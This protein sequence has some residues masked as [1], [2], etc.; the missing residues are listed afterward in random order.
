M[1]SRLLDRTD[2]SRSAFTGLCGETRICKWVALTRVV[3]RARRAR[4]L[5]FL[6]CTSLH[7]PNRRGRDEIHDEPQGVAGRGRAGRGAGAAVGAAGACRA[8]RL[9]RHLQD[10]GRGLSTLEGDGD[11]QLADR[12]LRSAADQLARLPQSRR[13]GGERDDVMGPRQR[14]AGALSFRTR[15]VQRQVLDDSHDAGRQLSGDRHGDGVDAWDGRRGQ[16]RR[17]V[18]AI[19]ERRRPR[20]V[21]GQAAGQGRL[22]AGAA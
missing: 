13:V 16:R 14:Q 4:G 21:Q 5:S 12:R 8:H 18:R 20:T 22:H 15:L 6:F 2:N 1:H 17:R 7:F 3:S 10:Q 19:G 9:R 11:S